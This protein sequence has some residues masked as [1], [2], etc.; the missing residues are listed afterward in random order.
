MIGN[1]GVWVG[2]GHSGNSEI[3]GLRTTYHQVE[4]RKSMV[5]LGSA[6]TVRTLYFVTRPPIISED[7]ASERI[8]Q[9]IKAW[10]KSCLK[11]E[12]LSPNVLSR[13][14][15]S[16]SKVTNDPRYVVV[17]YE[18]V[19]EPDPKVVERYQPYVIQP[20]VRADGV[21]HDMDWYCPART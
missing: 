8:S 11:Q 16:L 7:A 15:F 14:T 21:A 3:D 10:T 9:C 19:S 5:L 4:M 20:S 13:A 1:D 12:G 6:A 17:N 2:S 18:F